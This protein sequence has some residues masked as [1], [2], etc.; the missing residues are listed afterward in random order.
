MT[1]TVLAFD[2]CKHGYQAI[3]IGHIDIEYEWYLKQVTERC[4][5]EGKSVNECGVNNPD[6]ITAIEYQQQIIYKID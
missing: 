1:A 5:I 6:D 4:P 3:D 2:L